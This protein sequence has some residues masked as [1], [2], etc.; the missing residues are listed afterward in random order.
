MPNGVEVLAYK[1][2][3]ISIGCHIFAGPELITDSKT[4]H[5]SGTP[6]LTNALERSDQNVNVGLHSQVIRLINGATFVSDD[7]VMIDPRDRGA[8]KTIASEA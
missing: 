1:M 4:L 8:I 6:E 2:L 7:V 5:D 3:N